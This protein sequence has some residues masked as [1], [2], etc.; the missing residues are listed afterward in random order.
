MLYGLV[1][2]FV[3]RFKVFNC[4]SWNEFTELNSSLFTGSTPR[5][6]APLRKLTA[7][8]ILKRSAR[9]PSLCVHFYRASQQDNY[10]HDAAMRTRARTTRLPSE[11]R[12]TI[13]R[14]QNHSKA[15][16]KCS[17]KLLDFLPSS[18]KIASFFIIASRNLLASRVRCASQL[19]SRR[20]HV[21]TI[22]RRFASSARM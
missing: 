15:V 22:A 10:A 11:E 4:N 1:R 12:T 14:E 18:K 20:I 9:R 3:I 6:K 8:A 17:K 7:A 13:Q 21:K 19:D 16:A 2:T 5:S